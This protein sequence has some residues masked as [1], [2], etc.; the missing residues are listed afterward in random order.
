M[1]R[2]VLWE[3]LLLFLPIGALSLNSIYPLPVEK[4]DPPSST[5][6]LDRNGEILRVFLSK[7]DT[8][9]IDEPITRPNLA[10]TS[11]SDASV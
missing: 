2:Q 8:W 5:V 4:L 9:Q 1:K 3:S 6:I 10:N 11:I 7:N